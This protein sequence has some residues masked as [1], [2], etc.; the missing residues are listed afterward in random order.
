MGRNVHMLELN[1]DSNK[2]VSGSVSSKTGEN[3]WIM[4]RK[5]TPCLPEAEGISVDS[6]ET[7]S[8]VLPSQ[9]GCHCQRLLIIQQYLL[10]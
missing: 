9:K 8:A 3:D 1:E 5:R 6:S 2:K 7:P 4:G 10:L